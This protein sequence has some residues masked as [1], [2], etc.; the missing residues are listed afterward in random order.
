MRTG[1]Y[2]KLKVD[3]RTDAS[4]LGGFAQLLLLDVLGNQGVMI[5]D[6]RD[7]KAQVKG[8]Q[9]SIEGNLTQAGLRQVLSVF[10]P[11]TAIVSDEESTDKKSADPKR[12]PANQAAYASQQYFQSVSRL[13]DDVRNKKDVKT[14]AQY[15][16]W[17][18]KYVLKIDRLPL[19]NVDSELLDYGAFVSEKMR[20]ASMSVKG[21]AMNT[22]RARGQ[23]GAGLRLR[24]GATVHDG[25]LVR[26]ICFAALRKS[27]ATDRDQRRGKGAGRAVGNRNRAGDRQGHG[28]SPSCDDG[29]VQN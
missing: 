13:L 14:I 7:W 26:Q 25:S 20:D 27:A 29:E 23:S 28:S 18:S 15:G 8:S 24:C 10:E 19:V 12:D 3:F 4:I 5:D 17:F 21:I 22:A 2:G 9:I 16:T 1:S 6:F 11:P